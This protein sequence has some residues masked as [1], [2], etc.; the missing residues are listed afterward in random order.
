[1]EEEDARIRQEQENKKRRQE[2]I[3][4]KEQEDDGSEESK[5]VSSKKKKNPFRKV[6]KD[7]KSKP[8]GKL[9][10]T[11]SIE[12]NNK[13]NGEQ[14]IDNSNLNVEETSKNQLSEEEKALVKR[15]LTEEA[16]K[17]NST[18]NLEET[19]HD[20]EKADRSEQ[21]QNG[22]NNKNNENS[23]HVGEETSNQRIRSKEAAKKMLEMQRNKFKMSI[24]EAAF[25][26]DEVTD[27]L[28]KKNGSLNIS[29]DNIPEDHSSGKIE[30]KG[31]EKNSKKKSDKLSGKKSQN[32]ANDENLFRIKPLND[33]VLGKTGWECCVE[34]KHNGFCDDL[35]HK[36][37]YL[38][39]ILGDVENDPNADAEVCSCY[40]CKSGAVHNGCVYRELMRLK[41]DYRLF[42]RRNLCLCNVCVPFKYRKM[43]L[44][45]ELRLL[46]KN[47]KNLYYRLTHH[48]EDGN[49]GYHPNEFREYSN[50][51]FDQE[52]ETNEMANDDK[53][54]D[55]MSLDEI[56]LDLVN[57]DKIDFRN[58][59]DCQFNGFCDNLRHKK[60]YL[61]LI[62]ID[63]EDFEDLEDE[64]G[65]L[66][67]EFGG[68][69]HSGCVQRE[70][71]RLKYDVLLF[72][73][74]NLCTCRECVPFKYRSICLRQEMKLLRRN[75][76]VNLYKNL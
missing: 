61:L 56:D 9:Q 55:A 35:V 45:Q 1:M 36:A 51:N 37:E 65:C 38:T 76:G 29:M 30:V 8:K 39:I 70:M 34:C 18:E 23:E 2:E 67:C 72:D 11:L 43:C 17:E 44:R 4:R 47:G 74:R 14:N 15:L 31:G 52:D 13:D 71:K 19:P 32:K 10:L 66:V 73:K 28:P 60:L 49:E 25:D 21:N 48:G 62:H 26:N 50:D 69:A 7:D 53:P 12:E 68:A 5:N 6:K 41:T 75:H 24:D 22:E 58:C 27:M 59:I 63:D 42:D 33:L 46:R 16:K 3:R 64:C 20:K 54:I 57:A 40:V